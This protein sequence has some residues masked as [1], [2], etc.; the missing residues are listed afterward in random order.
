MMGDVDQQILLDEALHARV[1]RH[2]GD[3][4]ERRGRD[5]DVGDEDTSVVVVPGELLNEGSH[6]LHADGVVADELNV[7]ATDVWGWWVRF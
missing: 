3:N 1:L 6:V 5:V 2:S 4:L 7:N